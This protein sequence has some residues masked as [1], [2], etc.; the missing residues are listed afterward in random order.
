LE[1]TGSMFVVE[2]P[3]RED[4]RWTSNDIH[5]T[6]PMIG[7]K[8]RKA[9]GAALELEEMATLAAG[10]GP[11]LRAALGRY[12][13]GTRRDL[14]L[15]LDDLSITVEDP[16]SKSGSVAPRSRSLVAEMSLPS[17]GYATEVIRQFSREPFFRYSG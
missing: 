1:G 7:P 15:W 6:G 16:Q 13:D 5:P 14:L 8:M 2:D 12:A 3:A 11:E 4:A 10:L 17:G 9:H